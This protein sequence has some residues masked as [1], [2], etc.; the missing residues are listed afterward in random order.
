MLHTMFKF[1]SWQF[2]IERKIFLFSSGLRKSILEKLFFPHNSSTILPCY[3]FGLNLE[4]QDQSLTFIVLSI[5]ILFLWLPITL[6]IISVMAIL[7]SAIMPTPTFR[8]YVIPMMWHFCVIFSSLNFLSGSS[9]SFEIINLKHYFLLKC[10][11]CPD[12]PLL[13]C[14]MHYYFSI[15]RQKFLNIN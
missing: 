8:L 1:S 3:Y 6:L 13:S 4:P 14:S 15:Y 12:S 9:W 2:S 5:L 11:F 7:P 10:W